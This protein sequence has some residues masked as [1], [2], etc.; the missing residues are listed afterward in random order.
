MADMIQDLFY[1]LRVLRKS[2]GFT[3]IA[4]LTIAL[5]I[6]ANTAIFS[7][8]NA[9]LLRQV[10]FP[11]AD[12]LM[13]IHR[14]E[15][16]TI[17][18]MEF[19]DLQSQQQSFSAISL[20]RRETY[21]FSRTTGAE[22]VVG[23]MVSS[24][25]FSILG[26]K[27]IAGRALRQ[28][29]DRLGAAPVA[30]LT[31]DF[32]RTKLA[33]DPA[34]LTRTITLSG[35][36]YAVVGIVPQLPN[37]FSHT[38]IFTAIGQWSEPA[39][40]K[41]GVGMGTVAIGRLK[42]GVNQAQMNSDFARIS[43][44]I[45]KTYPK[46]DV[47]L[48]F[49]AKTFRDYSTG[50]LRPT[51]LLL[52]GAV[53]FV[54]LIACANVANLLLAKSGARAREFATRIA[55]GAG[56]ARVI[57]QLL[58]E[59]TL[60]ALLGGGLGLI[61]SA[62][63]MHAMVAAAPAGALGTEPVNIDSNV[64]LFALGASIL[65]GLLFGLA[66]AL[67]ISRA[68]LQSTLR[69]GGRT[70][71]GKHQRTQAALIVSEIALAMVLVVG[72]GL[73]IRS[74]VRVLAVDPGFNSHNVLTFGV[75]LSP[76]RSTSAPK[77]RTMYDDLIDDLHGVPG[78]SS[79]AAVFGNLPLTG[80]A[81]IA[82]WR[83]D[84]PRPESLH[85]GPGALWYAV[86][87]EY[88]SA[89]GIPLVRGRFIE[90]QDSETAVPIVVIDAKMARNLYPGEEAIGKQL[91]LSFFDITARIVGVVGDVKH[92][93][94][95]VAPDP[96]NF[97]QVYLSFHQVPERLVPMFARYSS[98]VVR[99]VVPPGTLAAAARQE[100]KSLDSQQVMYGEATMDE[101]LDTSL[102]FRRFSMLLMTVFAALAL[103]LACV[104]IYGVISYLVAQRTHEI[105]VRMALG[106]QPRDVLRLVLG[107]TLRLELAGVIVG[108]AIALPLTK[109]YSKMLFGISPSDPAT[110][111][112]VAMILA[113]VGLLACWIP[114]HRASRVD[115]LIALR[116]E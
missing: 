75:A 109:L 70:T 76:E 9:A 33:A 114:A 14:S 108:I 96:P 11:D 32:W 69:E 30:V 90:P 97:F 99:S 12:R 98:T 1:A 106:A 92:F 80:E 116:Y 47:H 95:D 50:D 67:R 110:F 74:L 87:P 13:M 94:V 83:Q 44:A 61:L 6:G 112:G 111:V 64:L 40:R 60:L 56:R 39:F 42:H 15:G 113:A 115:P 55:L 107:R 93:G 19:L 71:T 41:R 45:A 102:A 53:G 78:V 34:I 88:L 59:T 105:G 72:A 86:T 77:I 29:D 79:V 51:L 2:P 82:V 43:A 66:P 38:D 103:L 89:M 20:Y 4:I 101:L 91:H 21:S 63:G 36:D 49:T 8:V 26:L 16:A 7:V 57:R 31:E 28:E 62:W 85:Q 52:F 10:A 3:A 73:M 22:R 17:P 23:R 100:V 5:G 58:T 81:D 68:G 37:F 35:Q 84:R 54:L 65:T 27:I 18:Y 48:T 24:D 104:G 46:E 25:F